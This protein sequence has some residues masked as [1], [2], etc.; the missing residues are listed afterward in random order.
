VGAEERAGAGD[1]DAGYGALKGECA[2]EGGGV[3]TGGQDGEA[4]GDEAGSA[5]GE[6][7]PDIDWR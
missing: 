4:A 3:F 6:R 2:V 5:A 1:A 7:N